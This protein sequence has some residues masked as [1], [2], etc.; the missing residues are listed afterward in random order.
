MIE[1]EL[2]FKEFLES[3]QSNRTV[4]NF[5]IDSQ[6]NVESQLDA[7]FANDI[8]GC[9]VSTSKT[10]LV[11]EY[12]KK[13]DRRDVKL[14]GFDLISKNIELLKEGWIDFLINQN[15]ERQ[16]RKSLNKFINHFA[17]G[18]EVEERE[19]LPVEIIT[20]GNLTAAR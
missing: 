16:A 6:K 2:G 4:L 19:Y 7:A 12:L 13:R 18:E 14:I 15:P 5:G 9:L 17:F 3:G 10:W 11:A 1:K 8:A 20:K